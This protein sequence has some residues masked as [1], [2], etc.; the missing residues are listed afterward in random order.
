MSRGGSLGLKIAL[1][2]I[3]IL[4]AAALATGFIFA[5]MW[6]DAVEDAKGE[7]GNIASIFAEQTSQSVKAIDLVLD[8]LVTRVAWLSVENQDDFRQKLVDREE[9]DHLV[10][11]FNRLPQAEVLGFVDAN[12]DV[13]LTTRGWPTPAM[14]VVGHDPF[15]FLK[16]NRDAGLFVGVPVRNTANGNWTVYF[17]R[18]IESRTGEFLGIV[19]AGVPPAFFLGIS[20][21][22]SVVDG[23]YARLLR[24]DG[25]IYVTNPQ[26]E[27]RLGEKTLQEAEWLDLVA[28]GGGVLRT[29]STTTGTARFTAVQPVAGYP[30]VVDVGRSESSVIAIWR[31]RVV[32]IAIASVLLALLMA[33]LT[34]FLL[35]QFNRAIQRQSQLRERDERL[36]HTSKEREV[37]TARFEAAL[38]HMRQGLAV[39]DGDDRLVTCN[40]TYPSMYRIDP[41][42]L[43]PGTPFATILDLRVANGA[44]SGD[45]PALYVERHLRLAESRPANFTQIEQLRDGR[46]FMSSKQRMPDGGWLTIQE[47]VTERELAVAHLKYLASHDPLTGLANRSLLIERLRELHAAGETPGLVGLLMIDLDGFKAVNDK[48]GH[49]I[50]D[51]LLENVAARITAGVGSDDTVARLGGDEFAVLHISKEAD[52]HLLVTL[53][54]AVLARLHEPF[55][56]DRHVLKIGASI[57]VATAADG[58]IAPDA[59]LRRADLALYS[60][61]SSGRNRVVAFDK[62]MEVVITSR[63]ELAADLDAALDGGSLEVHYQPIVNAD[64]RATIAMEALARWRH[65]KL[66]AVTPAEFIPL[67][68]ETGQILR[69]GELVIERACESARHWPP[70]VSVAVNVSA[71]QV[72]QGDLPGLVSRH[73]KSAGLPGTRLEIEITESALLADDDRVRQTLDDLRAMGVRIVLDDF[74]TGF[75]SLSNLTRFSV[76]RIKIDRS[77]ISQLG[78][79][80][81]STAIVEASTMIAN[82]FGVLVT[83]EGVETMAQRN[84][85]RR[86]GVVQLQGYLYGAPAPAGDWIFE[87]GTAIAH[88]RVELAARAG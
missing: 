37:A 16:A 29:A 88:R 15:E 14:H 71:I 62:A 8:D 58:T 80:A 5:R 79:H 82:A 32:P 45:D 51:A 44:Y 53:G 26:E 52:P 66:G 23:L 36:A 60:A 84:L 56:I 27:N 49:A 2:A 87:P 86:M 72:A 61:K 81:G 68:E 31:A 70:R 13:L 11:R 19:T 34:A 41:R 22:A 20:D 85:L 4:V 63:R 64:T 46:F 39:F 78:S 47:D 69:L 83:A 42:L 6:S 25:T 38:A 57:G 24:E 28:K 17:G 65:P 21:G 40:D 35:I 55:Q 43:P 67:A 9:Y 1:S 3:T 18:R 73:L 12:G 59:V 48:F 33:V 76:D 75:A 77:F 50:G 74:G 54:S 7:V 10:A 30:L